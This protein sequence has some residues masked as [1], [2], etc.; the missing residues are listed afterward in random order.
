[1]PTLDARVEA[2]RAEVAAGR[3]TSD[4]AF[5]QWRSSARGRRW[6]VIILTIASFCPSLVALVLSAPLW[7]SIGLSVAAASIN[8]WLRRE[9]RRRLQDIVAWQEPA[10]LG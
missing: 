9:R 6:A 2:F 4:S 8:A 7:V 10:D 5:G 3:E 1:M